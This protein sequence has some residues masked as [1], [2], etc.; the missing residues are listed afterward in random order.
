M[1]LGAIGVV[2]PLVP[3][4]PFLLLAVACFA[5]SSR[6]F[7]V[8]LLGNRIF[9]PAFLLR[10]AARARQIQAEAALAIQKLAL[11]AEACLGEQVGNAF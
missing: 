3:T 2:L 1:G 9:G 5:R 11:E 8:W 6:R 7:Y 4:T 10:L